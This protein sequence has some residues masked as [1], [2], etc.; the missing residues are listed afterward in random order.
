MSKQK[1][2]GLNFRPSMADRYI[3]CPASVVISQDLP[4]DEGSS[5][6]NEGTVAHALAEKCLTAGG[7]PKD[8]LGVPILEDK[9]ID[10]PVG[11]RIVE[12]VNMYLDWIKNQ[13]FSEISVE[14]RYAFKWLKNPDGSTMGGTADL[15]AYSQDFDEWVISDYKNGVMPVPDDSLQFGTYAI[16]TMDKNN[17]SSVKTV[18]VQPNVMEG[19]RIGEHRWSKSDLVRLKAQIKNTIKWVKATKPEDIKETNFC[20]GY[21]CKFCPA[22]K[23][24]RCV[25]KTKEFFDEMGTDVVQL[26]PPSTMDEDKILRVLAKRSEFKQWLDDVYD[27]YF[28]EAYVNGKKI[29]GFK[30]V[31]GRA[32]PRAWRKDLKE[33]EIIDVLKAHGLDEDELHTKKLVTPAGAKK[34]LKKNFEQLDSIL[35]PLEKS[36]E[37]VAEDDLRKTVGGADFFPEGSGSEI[38]SGF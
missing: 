30:L 31:E 7:E 9:G 23:A 21:W 37:L 13:W 38:N 24:N 5:Y 19:S 17:A 4:V 22:K 11:E 32:K 33:A 26:P 18:R 29:E 34:I 20:Q 35:T 3:N 25:I 16:G 27:Y 2:M 15:E 8:F 6:A 1:T 36:V 10:I 28:R 14:Q 12:G